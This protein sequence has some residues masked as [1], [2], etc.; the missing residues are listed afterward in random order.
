MLLTARYIIYRLFLCFIYCIF[1]TIVNNWFLTEKSFYTDTFFSIVLSLIP[2]FLAL[3]LYLIRKT[4]LNPGSIQYAITSI[5]SD[6]IDP[7]RHWS[8]CDE[9]R[10]LNRTRPWGASLLQCA[11]ASSEGE[12]HRQRELSHDQYTEHCVNVNMSATAA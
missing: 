9:C 8:P 6:P 12:H 1:L 10:P 3:V 7:I 5:G 4:T 2:P 11:C